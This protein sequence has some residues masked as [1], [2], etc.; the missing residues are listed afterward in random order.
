MLIH[1]DYAGSVADPRMIEGDIFRDSFRSPGSV[2]FVMTVFTRYFVDKLL[3]VVARHYG[4]GMCSRRSISFS[5]SRTREAMNSANGRS[6]VRARSNRSI[7]S[8]RR[9]GGITAGR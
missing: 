7:Y 8:L 5:L 1:R 6:S 2:G 9:I 3:Q 4:S